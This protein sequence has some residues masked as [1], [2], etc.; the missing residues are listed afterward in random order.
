MGTDDQPDPERA[1]N[2]DADPR[3]KLTPTKIV[4]AVI[5]LAAIVLPLLTSS[6]SRVD[7]RLFGFPFFY[8]YQFLWVFLAAACCWISYVL[9]R[10]EQRAYQRSHGG[11]LTPPTGPPPSDPPPEESATDPNPKAE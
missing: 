6:Y 1:G 3:W 7:P 5:L 11:T 2:P 9:L 4:V 8:W 10:R